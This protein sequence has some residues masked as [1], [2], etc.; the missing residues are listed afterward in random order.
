MEPWGEMLVGLA[1]AVGIAGVVVPILPACCWCGPQS[2][3]GASWRAVRPAGAWSPERPS[4]QRV[5]QVVKYVVPG[6]RL[7][8][9]GVPDHALLVGGLVGIV[10]FF[11]IPVVGLFVGFAAGVYVAE[12]LRLH[13]HRAAWSATGHALR[14]AG[15]SILLE[16]AAAMLI[17]A[18]W[19]GA[20]A[21]T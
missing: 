10:G 16:L 5:S 15:L 18:G 7:R 20:L 21:L 17:A 12:R 1:V 2:S 19:V 9:A 8:R 3:S 14:A 4:S 13:D 6:R 11:V